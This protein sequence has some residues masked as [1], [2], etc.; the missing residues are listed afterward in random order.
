[1]K[2]EQY[3]PTY[4]YGFEDEHIDVKSFDELMDIEWIKNWSKDK[5]FHQYSIS[6]DRDWK[7]HNRDKPQHTLM[8]ELKNGT[9]WWVIAI[10][11]EENI[12]II[13]DNLREWNPVYST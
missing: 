8:C 2:V 3:R 13:I 12:G 7:K 11:R 6:I 9:E 1:M 10:V 5:D 4:F